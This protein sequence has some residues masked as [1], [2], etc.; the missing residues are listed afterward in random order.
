MTLT[1]QVSGHNHQI[2]KEWIS[3][4]FYDALYFLRKSETRGHLGG[5]QGLWDEIR[6]RIVPSGANAGPT[7]LTHARDEG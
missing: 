6:N 4:T 2:S 7:L 3:S 5:I 1:S